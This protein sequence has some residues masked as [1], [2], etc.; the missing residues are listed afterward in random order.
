MSMPQPLYYIK[1]PL[2][3]DVT[4]WGWCKYVPEMHYE[5]T[6]QCYQSNEREGHLEGVKYPEKKVFP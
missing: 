3:Y 1:E 6:F 4:Q 2:K 5:G